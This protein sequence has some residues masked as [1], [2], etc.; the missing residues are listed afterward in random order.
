MRYELYPR[1]G[2]LFTLGAF[3]KYF[4]KPIEYYFNRTG[5][6]TNTFNILNTDQAIAIG[7][8][9]E[10]RK[11]LDFTPALK[12]FTVSGNFSYI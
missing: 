4:D 7:A 12:N 5:P 9:L 2:E 10:F 1:S 11:K 8:E 3:F 6:G